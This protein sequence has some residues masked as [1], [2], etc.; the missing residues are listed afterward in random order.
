MHRQV[1]PNL[2]LPPG[3]RSVAQCDDVHAID[4]PHDDDDCR[5]AQQGLV[6]GKRRNNAARRDCE[7]SDQRQRGA[8]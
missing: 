1:A 8:R 5:Q 2:E 6:K 3:A 7:R 4:R